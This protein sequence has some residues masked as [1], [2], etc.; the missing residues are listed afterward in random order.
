MTRKPIQMRSMLICTLASVL[1]AGCT[2]MLLGGGGSAG[3]PI[4]GA[5]SGVQASDLR[6]EATIRAR[7]SASSVLDDA[8]LTVQSVDGVVTLRGDVP[9]YPAR[10]HAVRLATDVDGV[11]RVSNQIQIRR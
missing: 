11:Q 9:A 2:G 7:F 10:D 8:R 3:R 1:L 4:G 6:I 5:S